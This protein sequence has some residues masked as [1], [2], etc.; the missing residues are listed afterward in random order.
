MS[1]HSAVLV[2]LALTGTLMGAPAEAVQRAFVASYGSDANVATS[3]GMAN[4]CRGFAAAVT[5]VDPNGEVLALDSV[6]YGAV[7]LTQSVSLVAAPGFY[8]GISVP[9]GNG[10]TIATAGIS[11][12]LRGLNINGVGGA[13]G[14]SMTNGS[15]L[16]IE[17][18]VISNFAAGT[19][20]SITTGA[21]VRIVDSLIRD[22][23][24]GVYV[25]NGGT[26][27]IAGSK[28]LGNTSV[29]LNVEGFPGGTTATVAVSDSV[30]SNNNFGLQVIAFATNPAAARVSMIRSTLSNNVNGASVNASVGTA[31]LTIGNSMVTDNS[32]FGLRQS[33]LGTIESLV[34]N[35]VRQNGT[36]TSGTITP[37]API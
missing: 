17:N 33:N 3:C 14:V 12:T 37:V 24:I 29:G 36:N 19:G 21:T 6:G 34:D 35:I 20:V 1:R 31:L 13:M 26:A 5:V 8:A 11:V 23:N 28:I 25:T 4:P 18:C 2:A 22:S 16:S 15:R 10:V 27:S 7:T 9:T 30:L 32:G